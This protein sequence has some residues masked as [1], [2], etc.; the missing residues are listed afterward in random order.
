MFTL[1]KD[2]TIR[3][4]FGSK[5]PEK[6]ASEGPKMIEPFQFSIGNQ[7]HQVFHA[8][9]DYLSLLADVF[10]EYKVGNKAIAPYYESE[11]RKHL[12]SPENILIICNLIY[13]HKRLAYKHKAA[14]SLTQELLSDVRRSIV[15]SRAALNAHRPKEGNT[16]NAYQE[17]LQLNHNLMELCGF[18]L[19][20]ES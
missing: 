16:G 1:L 2:Y 18:G 9:A 15:N 6:P 5:A 19:F 3:F 7:N 13:Q 12:D 17:I 11:L 8:A 10:T 20:D 4:A 14:F